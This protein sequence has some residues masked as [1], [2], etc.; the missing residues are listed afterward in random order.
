MAAF[1][2]FVPPKTN[3]T[4]KVEER[5]SCRGR[6]GERRMAFAEAADADFTVGR[7]RDRK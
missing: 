4:G 2:A 3:A 1:V 5:S 6:T 7:T